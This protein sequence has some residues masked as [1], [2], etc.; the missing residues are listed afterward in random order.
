MEDRIDE[1]IREISDWSEEDIQELA[2]HIDDLLNAIEED[3]VRM[4]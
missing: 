1:I 3:A 2:S 4:S